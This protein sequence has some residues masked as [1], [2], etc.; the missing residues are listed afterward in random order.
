[1]L[2]DMK[3]QMKEQ[4]AQPYIQ[5]EETVMSSANQSLKYI[6]DG[7]KLKSQCDTPTNVGHP[8]R[9]QPSYKR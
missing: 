4:R 3:E 1:M 7:E 2:A 8:N 6:N 9:G 5:L